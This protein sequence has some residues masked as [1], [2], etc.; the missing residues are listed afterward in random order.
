[1][2]GTGFPVLTDKHEG[3][4][5]VQKEVLWSLKLAAITGPEYERV[6]WTETLEEIAYGEYQN[7]CRAQAAKFEDMCLYRALLHDK[8]HGLSNLIARV[9]CTLNSHKPPGHVKIR[10]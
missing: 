1:M 2:L 5:L 4:A 7:A 3:F 10:Q 6:S 9:G 8:S